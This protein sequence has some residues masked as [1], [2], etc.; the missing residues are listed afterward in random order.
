MPL[1]AARR[2]GRCSDR[3]TTSR[4]L[5][6]EPTL[7]TTIR[8]FLTDGAADGVWIV[9]KSNWTGKALMAPRT[10]Y[11]DL[12]PRLDGP[13]VYVL[14]GPTDSGVPPERLYIGETD[15]LRG[16]LDSHNANKDFWNRAIVFTSKDDNL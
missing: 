11:K 7:G 2:C 1:R 8:I 14:S 6:T 3:P 13:G 4:P 15:D 12:R 5:M 16:R 10:R 9:E